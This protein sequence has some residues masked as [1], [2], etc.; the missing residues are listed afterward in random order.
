M[1][2][3]DDLWLVDSMWRAA[4]LKRA[5]L[6][7]DRAGIAACLADLDT[8][9][10]ERVL[11]W[12]VLNHDDLFGELGEPSMAVREIGAAAA[13]APMEVEFAVTTAVRRVATKEKR[14]L[15]QAVEGLPL[16]DQIH[17]IVIC[18][19]V[20]LLEAFGRTRAL[21]K[22]HEESVAHERMGNPRP[23]TIS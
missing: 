3:T 18:T 14:G 7:Q 22:L 20:M 6:T 5:Y 17:T 13:L 11:V 4:D 21:E 23:Y 19:V 16:Q 8:G 10:L 2:E 9:Q 12:L 15:T 1:T